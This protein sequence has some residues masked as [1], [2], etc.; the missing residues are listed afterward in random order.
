MT[1]RSCLLAI[2]LS[3]AVVHAQNVNTAVQTNADKKFDFSVLKTYSWE[4]GHESFDPVSHKAI[5]AAVDAELAALGL[6]KQAGKGDVA[7]RYHSVARTG[8]DLK[9]QKKGESAPTYDVGKVAVELLAGQSFKR[10]W[11]ATTEERLSKDASAREVEIQRAIARIFA[12][13]PGRK[14]PA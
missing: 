10:V 9:S 12:S 1:T 11:Q 2:L 13:Y 8:V 14:K 6:V 3:S 7:V 4:K 5:V